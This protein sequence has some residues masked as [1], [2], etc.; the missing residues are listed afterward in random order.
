V[1]LDLPPP[2]WLPSRPA[3]IRAASPDLIPR[4][5]PTFE[6]VDHRVLGLFL[7]LFGGGVANRTAG[8]TGNTG[9]DLTT[10]TFSSVSWGQARGNSKVIALMV[11]YSNTAANHTLNT[12]TFGGASGAIEVQEYAAGPVAVATV[13]A[14]CSITSTS[15]SGDI[16]ATYN[17]GMNGASVYVYRLNNLVTVTPYATASATTG[18]SATGTTANTTIN[19]PDVGILLV[20]AMTQQFTPSVT[21]VTS[22]ATQVTEF[23]GPTPL[24]SS[25][26]GS[27][28]SMSSETNRAINASISSANVLTTAMASWQ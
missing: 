7:P 28:Q 27:N 17:G 21:G 24:G 25:M 4:I 12:I 3:I 8:G 16:V 23:S 15:Q 11:A 10:Y 1:P 2:L 6:L 14:V 26:A 13:A 22:D 5:R 19:I 9:S 20:T 18:H